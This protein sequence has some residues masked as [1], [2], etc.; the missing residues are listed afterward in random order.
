MDVND[1]IVYRITKEELAASTHEELVGEVE[2]LRDLLIR[3]WQASGLLGERM[4]GQP[5]Q[6]WEEPSD[7]I[8]QIDQLW[9]DAENWRTEQND[10]T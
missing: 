4:T 2:R 1:S 9:S 3:C 6:A 10:A 7:L 8:A 5:F